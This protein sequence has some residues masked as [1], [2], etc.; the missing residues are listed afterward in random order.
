MLQ[1][2][3]HCSL[4][5]QLK[6][7]IFLLQ[8]DHNVWLLSLLSRSR[9]Q[10]HSAYAAYQIQEFSLHSWNMHVCTDLKILLITDADIGANA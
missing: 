9:C 3:G 10:L 2:A 5:W 1:G 7:H 6:A 4:L 8:I